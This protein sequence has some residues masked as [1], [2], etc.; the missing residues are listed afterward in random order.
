MKELISIIV[1][2]YNVENYLDKCIRSILEQTYSKIE[3]ILVN[4]GSTDNSYLI[5]EK[6]SKIDSRIVFIQKKNGGLSD[7]RNVGIEKCNGK[8]IA[9]VDSDD[10]IEPE[11]IEKLYNILKE[12]DADISICSFNIVDLNGKKIHEEILKET[13][14]ICVSGKNILTNVLT[15]Y[16]YKY[17][18][19]WNKLYKSEIFFENKFDK[20]KLYEDEFISFRI[21]YDI[22]KVALIKDTLYN[23]VQREGSIKLSN[24]TKEK[25]EM[26]REMHI[27]RIKFYEEKKNIQLHKK[28]QQMYCNWIISCYVD[29]KKILSDRQKQILQNDMRKFAIRIGIQSK[30]QFS[31]FLQNI[32]GVINLNLASNVKK[33]YKRYAN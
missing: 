10:Y 20:G 24:I 26:Q 21:F 1:P 18:V 23:Y 27:T 33:M 32:L 14:Q 12:N 13:N 11:Y 31:V 28:A 29:N 16:G 30:S 7:A 8:Y 9:F 2:I 15:P 22:D 6:Y 4:D 5:C 19:S 3:I 25:I 17:V